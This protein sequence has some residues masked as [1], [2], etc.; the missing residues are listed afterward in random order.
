MDKRKRKLKLF[1]L[2]ISLLLSLGLE[3][4]KKIEPE[5]Q[6]GKKG[7]TTGKVEDPPPIEEDFQLPEETEHE[8]VS[9]DAEK[10]VA[11]LL[12]KELSGFF[13]TFIIGQGHNSVAMPITDSMFFY[14]FV[15]HN[16]EPLASSEKGRDVLYKYISNSEKAA[17]TSF[18]DDFVSDDPLEYRMEVYKLATIQ[19]K[20]NKIWGSN[21]IDLKKWFTSGETQYAY[22][23]PT[24]YLILWANE[25]GS[26]MDLTAFYK[27]VGS[28]AISGKSNRYAVKVKM[29]A[30][31]DLASDS[32]QIHDFANNIGYGNLHKVKS[33][34]ITSFDEL[35]KSIKFSTDI[36]VLEIEVVK[37]NNGWQLIGRNDFNRVLDSEEI[38]E[39]IWGMLPNYLVSTETMLFKGPGEEYAEITTLPKG[40]YLTCFGWAKKDKGWFYVDYRDEDNYRYYKGWVKE[41]HLIPD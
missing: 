17:F 18:L 33:S 27:I 12:D 38:V 16:I 3:A 8:S 2:I 35:L 23:S 26:D 4:C 30:V 13:G 25:E 29:I 9:A 10:Y 5:S 36:G 40:A 31:W 11:G 41:K 39:Y 15:S 24:G 22:L 6:L 21:R 19:E 7:K 37:N 1:L 20:F 14:W 34:E 28:S 32:I